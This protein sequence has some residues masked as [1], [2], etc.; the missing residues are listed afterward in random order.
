M[1]FSRQ[2]YWR[3]VPL[4]RDILLIKNKHRK[5]CVFVFCGFLT[6][7]LKLSVLKTSHI[8]Y[9]TVSAGK[10]G[11]FL[12]GSSYQGL[13]SMSN[14]GRSTFKLNLVTDRI[15]FLVTVWLRALASFRLWLEP[16]SDARSHPQFLALWTSPQAVHIMATGL[17][18]GIRRIFLVRQQQSQAWQPITFVILYWIEA[19]HKFLWHLRGKNHTPL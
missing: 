18:E 16:L 13:T 3:E 8:F 17:F 6:N 15:H 12:I 7:C 19:S 10:S 4:K 1:G 2:E 11:H 9:L 14:Q 5:L